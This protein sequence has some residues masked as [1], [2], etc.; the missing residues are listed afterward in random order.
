[1]ISDVPIGVLVS[2]GI[3]STAI[4]SNII[5]LKK[6][7]NVNFFYAKQFVTTQN[8]ISDDDEYVKILAKGLKIKLNEINL[9]NEK[10]SIEEIFITLC[11]QFEEPFNIELSSISTYLISKQ[12]KE[13]GI[14]V[15]TME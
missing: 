1:M 10:S 9:L 6:D 2:G 3:D 12:M 14:K 5:K 8:K 7:K 4:L 11:K 15:V 13:R